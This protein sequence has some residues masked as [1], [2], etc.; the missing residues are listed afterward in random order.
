VRGRPPHLRYESPWVMRR[1]LLAEGFREARLHWLPVLPG[2]FC[3][4]G[5]QLAR[6]PAR[7][8]LR[9]LGPA[10]ALLSHSFLI[11]ALRA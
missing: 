2:R 6:A 10:A 7:R 1:S 4:L 5:L 11:E 9:I 8:A 3:R